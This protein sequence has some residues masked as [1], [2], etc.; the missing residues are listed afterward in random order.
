MRGCGLETGKDL[1]V[2]KMRS[3]LLLCNEPVALVINA[4]L[5]KL[6]SDTDN[7]DIWWVVTESCQHKETTNTGLELGLPA[8]PFVLMPW[9][10]TSLPEEPAFY[11]IFYFSIA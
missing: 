5:G 1:F 7:L 6:L 11:Y 8:P 2:G 3:L 4:L 10:R 9:Y